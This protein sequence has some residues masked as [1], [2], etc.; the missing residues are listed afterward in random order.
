MARL[1]GES[2]P[3]NCSKP[4][5]SRTLLLRNEQLDVRLFLLGNT[6][7]RLTELTSRDARKLDEAKVKELV[8]SMNPLTGINDKERVNTLVRGLF[9]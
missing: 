6:V 8:I 9:S 1:L 4:C 7:F 5:D 2:I 3:E